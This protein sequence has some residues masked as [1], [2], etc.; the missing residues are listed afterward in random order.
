MLSNRTKE[1]ARTLWVLFASAPLSRRP[2][3]WPAMV[4]P[5]Q[6]VVG[7][8]IRRPRPILLCISLFRAVAEIPYHRHRGR[9][10]PGP[11]TQNKSCELGLKARTTCFVPT[12]NNNPTKVSEMHFDLAAS[13]QEKASFL[14]SGHQILESI[15]KNSPIFGSAHQILHSIQKNTFFLEV[16]AIYSLQSLYRYHFKD[17]QP[18]CLQ[19]L[20]SDFYRRLLISMVYSL[21]KS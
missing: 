6:Q 20:Q 8:R 2:C 17:C 5:N 18:F 14:G 1:S 11:T 13:F 10:K 19:T 7:R 21:Q 4:R 16:Y 12:S 15:Q 9:P 3:F